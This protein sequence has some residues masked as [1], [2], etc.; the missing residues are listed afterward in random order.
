MK[1]TIA[2]CTLMAWVSMAVAQ[3]PPGPPTPAPAPGTL[4]GLPPQIANPQG[5][6]PGLP[7]GIGRVL[8][9]KPNPIVIDFTRFEGRQACAPDAGAD[10]CEKVA[11]KFCAEIGYAKAKLLGIG[12]KGASSHRAGVVCHSN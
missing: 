10:S 7:P 6:P 4:P 5:I 2:A 3:T 1:A 8:A 12:S 11:E 9:I